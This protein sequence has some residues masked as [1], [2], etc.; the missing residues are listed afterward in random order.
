MIRLIITRLVHRS[1]D[2]VSMAHRLQRFPETLTALT[3][4]LTPQGGVGGGPRGADRGH[5]GA[6]ARDPGPGRRLRRRRA[7]A[8]HRVDQRLARD[9][10]HHQRLPGQARQVPQPAGE[11]RRGSWRL[12]YPADCCT[13]LTAVPTAGQ[14]GLP[15]DLGIWRAQLRSMVLPVICGAATAGQLGIDPAVGSLVS[16]Q[17]HVSSLHSC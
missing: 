9:G 11:R 10:G 13:L 4:I 2:S 14:R 1:H 17:C 7:D 16:G 8:H 15:S 5:P 3:L 12:L 6:Q